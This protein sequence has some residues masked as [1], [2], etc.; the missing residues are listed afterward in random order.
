MN[1]TTLRYFVEIA[2]C[3]S[4]S[5]A[6]ENLFVSQPALSR[7]LQRLEDEL[8]A[9]LF[10]RDKREVRLTAFGASCLDD[11]RQLLFIADRITSSARIASS[12]ESG[13]LTLGYNL[14]EGDF[15]FFL[16]DA[17]RKRFPEI[18]IHLRKHAAGDMPHLLQS[19]QLDAAFTHS[20]VQYADAI[21]VAFLDLMDSRLQL[22]VPTQ[23]PFAQRS[24]VNFAELKQE[25]FLLYDHES[26]PE[27][28]HYFY[29]TCISCGFSPRISDLTHMADSVFAYISAGYGIGT[30]QSACRNSIQVPGITCVDLLLP[31]GTDVLH[32]PIAL[33]YNKK[34][35]N[36]C[37]KSLLQVARTLAT[38]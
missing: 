8:G 15:R 37:L 1:I 31:D 5:R 10:I 38:G 33:G 6:A 13:T 26:F 3:G 35:S 16:L 18:K 4:F 32:T 11:A 20:G 12:G 23:H 36:P 14:G 2:D 34:N 30:M 7:S 24:A 19:G 22:V 25:Q 29:N 28:Y 27:I 9:Q 17:M 21:D